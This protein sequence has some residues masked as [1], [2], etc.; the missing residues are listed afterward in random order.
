M[1]EPGPERPPEWN[2]WLARA[3]HPEIEPPTV[4]LI[5][6]RK[7]LRVAGVTLGTSFVAG[8]GA[9][10]TPFT[11]SLWLFFASLAAGTTW[12]VLRD[13]RRLSRWREHLP[14]DV[15]GW[16]DQLPMKVLAGLVAP[17]WVRV[18]VEVESDEVP[19][20]QA[21]A[22]QVAAISAL[23]RKLPVPEDMPGPRDAQ[24]ACDGLGLQGAVDAPA[25]RLLLLFIAESLA[26]VARAL[27]GVK[28][29][30]F[31]RLDVPPRPALRVVA[32]L[33]TIGGE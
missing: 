19:T 10:V 27:P 11:G 2:A 1:N 22:A 6:A 8:I 28:R 24:W 14:F 18:E 3:L 5:L 7:P 20:K 30:T 29:V 26:P 13:H 15:V 4:Y 17:H 9:L 33:P 16:P 25:V 23:L 31:R 32:A 12:W 21:V